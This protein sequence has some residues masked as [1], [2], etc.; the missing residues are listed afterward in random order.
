MFQVNG[1]T[2]DVICRQG[3]SGEM[4]FT[5][6]STAKPYKAYF[7][8][9]NNKRKI[10]VE[11]EATPF[12]GTV[13]FGLTPEMMDKLEVPVGEKNMLYYYGIKICLPEENYEDTLVVGNKEITALNKITVYPKITEG[14]VE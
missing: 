9:Y 5:G 12:D 3:D 4:T 6:I 11:I 1:E 7:S 8:I 14:T 2:G 13:T 10:L